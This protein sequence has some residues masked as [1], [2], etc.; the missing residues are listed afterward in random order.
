MEIAPVSFVNREGKRIEGWPDYA[1]QLGELIDIA[2]DRHG[3]RTQITIFAD[4]QL[5]PDREARIEHMRL[6]LTGVLPGREHKVILLEVAN[7][8]WQNGFPGDEG[9][10]D[11]KEFAR[12]LNDRTPIPVAMTSNHHDSFAD[13]Y[14]NGVADIATWHFSRDLRP[15]DGWKPVYDCWELGDMPGCPPVISNEPI[16]PGSSVA[17]ENRANRLVMAAAFAY[18]A[19][20]PAYV[21]HSEAGVF[22]K[23]RFEETPGIDRFGHLAQLLP[24]DLPNW[25]RHDGRDRD[26]PFAVFAGGQANKYITDVAN[27]EDGCL[28]MAGSRKGDRFVCVP[29]GIRS[30]GVQLE[31]KQAVSFS[32]YDPV[33]GELL[34]SMTARARERVKLPRGPEALIIV[35]RDL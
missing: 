27:S 17:A 7:E 14:G 32:V 30:G 34:M 22:G 18:V 12:Y 2:Y 13:L 5:M 6:I 31:A 3:M 1:K 20:L 8:A 19:K 35:G 21:F 24:N 15:D 33:T 9:V 4:A 10:A 23:S 11:L 25:E 29:I 16:G 28:R 26:A